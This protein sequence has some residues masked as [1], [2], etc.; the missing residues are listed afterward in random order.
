MKRERAQKLGIKK[1]SDLKNH[2]D[3]VIGIS[4]EYLKEKMVGILL[5]AYGLKFNNVSG[6][7]HDLAY[8]A[9]DYGK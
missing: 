1:I 4:H 8:R 5:R 3:L 6:F 9:L 7:Q 2:P